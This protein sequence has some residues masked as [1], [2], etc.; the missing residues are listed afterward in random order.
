VLAVCVALSLAGV[1]A[2]SACATD[3]SGAAPDRP[4]I[5]VTTAVLGAVVSEVV[6]DRAE[7]EVIVPNGAD[8]HEFRP[9]AKDLARIE[10][11]AL[12]VA[13]GAGLEPTLDDAL[14]AAED[15]GTSVFRAT[16]HVPL[17]AFADRDA[18][19]SDA[20]GG[21]AHEDG[22]DPHFWLDPLSMKLVVAA[23]GTELAR[24]AGL[25]V[26]AETNAMQARLDELN[27]EVASM[28]AVVPAER[29]VLVTGHES[30]GYFADRYGFTL[31]GAVIPSTTS[32]AASSAGGLAELKEAILRNRVPAI[33]T[34]LGTPPAVVRTIADETGVRVVELSTHTLPDDGSYPTFIR[35]LADGVVNGLAP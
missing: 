3:D 24:E 2:S 19:G 7:V 23:L 25:D 18:D 32:Q 17:R 6:G 21:D 5:V 15:G 33:F 27:A 9:S 14:D 31:V 8:P 35:D 34:E 16:D 20:D 30:L 22:R 12:V 26:A 28:L 29:R 11:A 10:G 4:T 1:L 13:N